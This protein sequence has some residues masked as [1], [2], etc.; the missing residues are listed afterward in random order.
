LLNLGP[1]VPNSKISRTCMTADSDALGMA[2]SSP[3]H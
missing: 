1:A 2:V 3:P